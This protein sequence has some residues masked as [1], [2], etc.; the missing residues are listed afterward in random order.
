MLVIPQLLYCYAPSSSF[1]SQKNMSNQVDSK[2]E[3]VVGW[4]GEADLKFKK[5]KIQKW[6]MESGKSHYTFFSFISF[7]KFLLQAI[8][9][10]VRSPMHFPGKAHY[11]WKERD[12]RPFAV[13]CWSF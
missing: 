2:E 7:V 5:V 13:S 12:V 11:V 4:F 1:I 9:V 8:K 10:L 3:K 6:K